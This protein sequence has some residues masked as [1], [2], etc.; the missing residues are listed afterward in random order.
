[1]QVKTST[2]PCGEGI[3]K[4]YKF[5][6]GLTVSAIRTPYS[7]GGR[8]GKWE[9]AVM[10]RDGDWFTKQIFLDAD[11]DVIGHLTKKQLNA[12]IKEVFEYGSK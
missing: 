5:S 4:I 3:Q 6:N 2:H 1:M 11:D 9:M 8:D 7:Y 12:N 10:T